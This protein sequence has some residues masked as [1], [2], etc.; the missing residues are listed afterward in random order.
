MIFKQRK[1]SGFVIWGAAA[2]LVVSFSFKKTNEVDPQSLLIE[3]VEALSQTD[4]QTQK[5]TRAKDGSTGSCYRDKEITIN[6]KKVTY[7]EFAGT[8]IDE[9]EQYEVTTGSPIVCKHD[10][11]HPCPQGT[12]RN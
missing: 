10:K 8:Y 5:C 9:V 2:I 7:P 11:V 6:G 1:N 12:Y 4:N 3:N